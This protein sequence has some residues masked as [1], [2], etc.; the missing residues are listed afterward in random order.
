MFYQDSNAI[1]IEYLD[2]NGEPQVRVEYLECDEEV[3]DVLEA[4]REEGC[5]IIR[6]YGW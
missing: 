2:P 1:R 6:W 3:K 5:E 4:Y